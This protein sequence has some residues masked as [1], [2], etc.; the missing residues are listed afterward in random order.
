M[1]SFV[2]VRNP[3]NRLASVYFEKNVRNPSNAW[4]GMNENII[5]KYRKEPFQNHAALNITLE[6]P[7]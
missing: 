4:G 1:T 6:T 2:L 5:A 3:F 7:L